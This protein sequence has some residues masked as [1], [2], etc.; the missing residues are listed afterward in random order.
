MKVILAISGILPRVKIHKCKAFTPSVFESSIS[1]LRVVLTLGDNRVDNRP[2]NS[3]DKQ[4]M[5]FMPKLECG[6]YRSCET[7]PQSRQ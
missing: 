7:F 4:G 3:M 5:I 2:D 1:L 6:F